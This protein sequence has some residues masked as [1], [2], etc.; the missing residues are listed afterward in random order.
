MPTPNII[1]E[2]IDANPWLI[3]LGDDIVDI[4]TTLIL[5]DT[6]ASLVAAEIRNTDTYRSRFAGLLARQEKGLPAISEREYLETELSFRNQLRNYEVFDLLFQS[7]DAFRDFAATQIGFDV[8]AAEMSRR[9]DR[10]F[11]SVVDA[12]PTVEEAF[13]QFYGVVPTD[14]ALLAYFLDPVR[15]TSEIENQ[16]A[17][18]IVGGEALAYGLNITRTRAEL[19]ASQGV[20]Q[21]FARQGFADIAR[22]QPLIERLSTIHQFTPLS[23]TDLESFFFHNDPEI[24]RQRQ[25]IFETALS[26]FRGPTARPLGEG[27]V[28][29]LIDIRRTV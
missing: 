9:L 12:R 6:P 15:G 5:N 13:A 16:V 27:G 10:G 8:S 25:Q 2:I 28:T 4:V 1:Q 24:R 29:E 22:E 18:A 17:A 19:F 11:A 23:Q 7:E 3:Q 14:N 21:Q 20:T 26:Q